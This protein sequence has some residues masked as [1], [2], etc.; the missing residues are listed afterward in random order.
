MRGAARREPHSDY[1]LR[2]LRTPSAAAGDPRAPGVVALEKIEKT[3]SDRT[4]S[5]NAAIDESSG[6]RRRSWAF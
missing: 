3:M 4:I 2:R 6:R 1:P 5:L